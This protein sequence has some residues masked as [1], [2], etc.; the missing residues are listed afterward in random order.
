VSHH[1]EQKLSPNLKK[2]TSLLKWKDCFRLIHPK[3]T[4]YSHHYNRQ[5]AGQGLAQ[6]GSRLDRAYMWGDVRVLD[7]EYVP[8]AF[9]DHM[10]H[11]VRVAGHSGLVGGC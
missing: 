9:S 4:T 2:L 11:L 5:M 7:A 8:V 10:L 1:P 3:T 6:G